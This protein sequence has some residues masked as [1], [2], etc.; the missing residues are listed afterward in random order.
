MAS[1]VGFGKENQGESCEGERVRAGVLG[2]RKPTVENGR[3]P[4]NFGAK[5]GDVRRGQRRGNRFEERKR[6]AYE[7]RG[8]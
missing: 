3:K 4:E 6:N 2:V 1:I 7:K 8:E 5:R